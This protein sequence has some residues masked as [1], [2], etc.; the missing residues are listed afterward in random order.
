MPVDRFALAL[1]LAASFLVAGCAGDACPENPR[2]IGKPWVCDEP[3]RFSFYLNARSL[4]IP[5]DYSWNNTKSAARINATFET[6][7]VGGVWLRVRD[8]ADSDLGETRI[9]EPGRLSKE[10]TTRAGLRGQWTLTL[11]YDGFSG[12]LSLK[13]YAVS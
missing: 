11:S 13:A 2:E 10:Y 4:S 6:G 1:A 12:E 9:L 5:A 3:D 8:A 7:S